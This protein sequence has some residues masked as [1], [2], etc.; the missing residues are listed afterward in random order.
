M[1]VRR[2]PTGPD[3]APAD[4][5]PEQA[6][7]RVHVEHVMGTAVV[8]TV[9]GA[10][11]GPEV[12]DAL[13]GACRMLHDADEVF[14][15]WNPSSP[16]TRLRRGEARLDQLDPRAAEQIS[17][18]L[19]LCRQACSLTEGWFDPWALPGGVDPTGLVKGWAIERAL[20]V[21]D[22]RGLTAMVNGGGDIAW[23]GQPPDG[24][25]RLGIR[26]PWVADG[27]ACVVVGDGVRRAIATSAGYE[28]GAHFVDP[29]TGEHTMG[30]LASGT[31]AG[32]DL[33]VADALATA[34]VVGGRPV[35]DAIR[36]LPDARGGGRYEA[37][38][39]GPAGEEWA[40]KGF[41]FAEAQP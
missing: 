31:V 13:A 38:A 29:F 39:I 37:Y 28:R 16:M 36:R 30:A 18:V 19:E 24:G 26:H 14:S 3:T 5:G 33:A 21:L 23:C 41:P 25:W 6:R 12:G 34:L 35:L 20:A 32:P 1:T 9:H 40:T 2:L 17:E 27:L 22:A 8:L 7:P 10:H 11:D 4:P 15:T